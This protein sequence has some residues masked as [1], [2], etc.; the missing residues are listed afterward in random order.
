MRPLDAQLVGARS[1]PLIE[2]SLNPWSFTPPVSLTSATLIPATETASR[3]PPSPPARPFRPA[4]RSRTAAPLARQAAPL[5]VG[6]LFP[7][8]HRLPPRPQRDVTSTS[9]TQG[10]LV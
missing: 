5:A 1:R 6:L 3:Q 9:K 4:H 7:P 2:N 8:P 10:S